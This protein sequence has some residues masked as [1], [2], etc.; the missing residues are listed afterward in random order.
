MCSILGVTIKREKTEYASA[1]MTFMGLELDSV[2]MEARLPSEKLDKLRSLLAHHAQRRKI[3]LK[4]L[5]ALLGL[6]NFCCKVV[7][8]G[9]CFLRRLYD[10]TKSVSYPMHRITL[11]KESRKDIKAWQIFAENFNG[12]QLLLNKRWLT[13]E[14]LHFYTDAAGSIGFGAVFKSHWFCGPWPENLMPHNI[15]WKELFPI[16]LALEIGCPQ[17]KNQ[18]ISLHSDNYAVVYILNK[19]TSKDQSIM[20]LVRRIVLCCMQH[21]LLVK[22]THI[23]GIFNILPDALARLQIEKFRR[24]APSMDKEPTPVP[25]HLL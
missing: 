1:C 23:P 8:P 17:L 6:L 20:H 22:S 7:V 14:S 12:R 2:A 11:T 3:T 25:G 15:T 16:V 13:S 9:H 4:D 19:Q 21:N 18:C 5:Q 24:L 10:L